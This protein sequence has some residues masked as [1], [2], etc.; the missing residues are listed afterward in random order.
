MQRDLVLRAKTGDH[1]AF[2][3]LAADAID[4]L[5]RTARLILR[6]S[7]R[8]SDAVQDAL[9]SAWLDIRAVRDPDRFDAWLNKLLVRACYRVAARER[10]RQLTE[11]HVEGL[12]APGPHDTQGIHALRD[13]LERGFRRLTPEQRAVLVLHHWLGLP[14]QEAAS[15]L[16]IP[17]GTYKSRLSR[18][19]IALRAAVDADDR[20]PAMASESVA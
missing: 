2:T 10:R 13:Q 9:L 6:D 7:D 15:V 17:L 14:D 18:A 19:T 8:A 4:R 20:G 16:G 12:D 5:H 1:A 11:I 3:A